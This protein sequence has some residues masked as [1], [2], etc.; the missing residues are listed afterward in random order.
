MAVTIYRQQWATTFTR[1]GDF[2]THNPVGGNYN[3]ITGYA[4][5]F[6]EGAAIKVVTPGTMEF[7]P[8]SFGA[9]ADYAAGVIHYQCGDLGDGKW[10]QGDGDVVIECTYRHKVLDTNNAIILA[11]SKGLFFTS[12]RLEMIDVDNWYI[13]WRLDNTSAVQ[14][15]FFDPGA[16]YTQ[17]N[18]D[19]VYKLLIKPGTV[20]GDPDGGTAAFSVAADGYYKVYIDGVLVREQTGIALTMGLNSGSNYAVNPTD[21]DAVW[22]GKDGLLGPTQDLHIYREEDLSS[23]P[24]NQSTPCCGSASGPGT[25][26]AG[27]AL[28]NNPFQAL[29]PWTPTCAGGGTVPTAA[30]LTDAESWA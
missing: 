2:Q 20:T 27:D 7:D 10:D 11:I 15:D 12:W 8:A 23:L 21:V 1:P 5:P 9:D 25:G 30:D 3:P 13:G 29:Q 22:Q 24:T 16:A 6:F 28:G 4:T 17:D 19:H 26:N 14:D 18:A